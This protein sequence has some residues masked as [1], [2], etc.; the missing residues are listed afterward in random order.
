M[1]SFTQFITSSIREVVF[2]LEDSLVSTLGAVTGIAV[3]TQSTYIVI[4]SG[5]VLIASE[6]TSMAAGSYLSIQT[7]EDV[8]HKAHRRSLHES[9][10]AGAVV[11]GIFYLAGGFVPL[12]T[13]FFLS[14][15][16]AIFPSVFVTLITLFF[17]G[18]VTA[19]MTKKPRGSRGL[20]MVVISLSA[21]LIGYTIGQL[22]N[23]FFGMT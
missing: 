13:Y 22:V 3:G 20:Q 5:L 9:P 16:Q 18:Y 17:V 10:V 23:R 6:S 11:M 21:A 15:Q 7:V 1:K 4:L 12:A 14:T 8:E 2:G 19:A